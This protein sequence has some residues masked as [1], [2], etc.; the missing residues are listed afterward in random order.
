[1]TDCDLDIEFSSKLEPVHFAMKHLTFQ[2]QWWQRAL[3]DVGQEKGI[4]RF[5]FA[6]NELILDKNLNFSNPKHIN[7]S[8]TAFC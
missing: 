4:K 8:N 3:T 6:N 5:T 2:T 7:A 1:M